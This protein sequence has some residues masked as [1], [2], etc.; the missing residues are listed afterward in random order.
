MFHRWINFAAL[1][2]R[3]VLG[4]IFVVHGA[5]KLFGWFGGSG[6]EAT[7]GFMASQGLV[8]GMLF[9]VVA[10]VLEFFGGLA[11]LAGLLTRW[12]AL[13]LAIEMLV[14]LVTVHLPKGFFA[15]QGGIEFPLVLIAGCVTLVCTGA[16]RYAVDARIPRLADW[17]E[18][19]VR[20][21]A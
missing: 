1:P 10:V 16:Q 4:V 7:A 12:V 20:R 13:L 9:A 21:A 19:Q 18:R 3:F 11:L 8:P 14:A 17:E 15:G 5:Q 6:L 2:L